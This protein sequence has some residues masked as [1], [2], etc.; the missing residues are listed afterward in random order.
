MADSTPI[1]TVDPIRIAIE[2]AISYHAT[3]LMH[4]LVNIAIGDVKGIYEQMSIAVL[5]IEPLLIE[6]ITTINA[7]MNK[8]IIGITEVLIS[9][10]FEAVEPIAPNINAYI[11][12]PRM[13]NIIR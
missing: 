5:S 13:K 6:N 9:S 10:S 4:I 11:K 12:N 3:V 7:I 8:N 2:I 1:P